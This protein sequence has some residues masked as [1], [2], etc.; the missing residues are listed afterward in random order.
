MLTARQFR[1]LKPGDRLQYDDRHIFSQKWLVAEVIVVKP[2]PRRVILDGKVSK[3]KGDCILMI[4]RVDSQA[5]IDPQTDS[6]YHLGRSSD[7]WC[8]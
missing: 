5:D 8:V 1:R 3:K 6:V 7:T 2:A 4:C